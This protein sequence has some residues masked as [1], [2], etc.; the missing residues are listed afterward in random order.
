MKH[1][2]AVFRV[3]H[4]GGAAVARPLAAERFEPIPFVDG[5]H[6]DPCLGLAVRLDDFERASG[7][8]SCA[9][10]PGRAQSRLCARGIGNAT[11]AEAAMPAL[12][13]SRRSMDIVFL[14]LE[15][16][17]GA[18]SRRGRFGESSRFF[19]LRSAVRRVVNERRDR[20]SRSWTRGLREITGKSR[21][22]HARRLGD[23]QSLS[24]SPA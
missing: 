20:R 15:V 5:G 16:H 13:S 9:T 21:R 23:A 14:L 24:P 8:Q 17:N 6:R 22:E 19:D 10:R 2:G 3:A 18:N 4:Q 7:P 1:L 11:A 12:R